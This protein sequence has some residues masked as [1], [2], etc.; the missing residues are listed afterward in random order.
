MI[1][2][3]TWL[4]TTMKTQ[5][6]LYVKLALLVEL[7]SKS[8]EYFWLYANHCKFFSFGGGN[9]WE[10]FYVSVLCM[11]A[12]YIDQSSI[13]VYYQHNTLISFIADFKMSDV[14]RMH[15]S[16]VEQLVPSI[17]ALKIKLQSFMSNGIFWMIYFIL[18]LPRFD[19][20]DFELLATS[21]VRFI[22][23]SNFRTL[24]F[25]IVWSLLWVWLMSNACCC[26]K[27]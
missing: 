26:T 22:S 23:L 5:F 25:S 18:L 9:Y 12:N 11:H 17:T 2:P 21:E 27:V 8:I 24:H 7:A 3:P 6:N 19:P 13:I 14:Q 4:A 20:P 10:I 15:I 16:T 1:L